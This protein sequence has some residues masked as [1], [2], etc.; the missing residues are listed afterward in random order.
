[1]KEQAVSSQMENHFLLV[2]TLLWEKKASVQGKTMA[3]N[4]S[5]IIWDSMEKHQRRSI[6]QWDFVEEEN[7]TTQQSHAKY[8][9]NCWPKIS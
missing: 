4:N 5:T 9:I 7:Q 2:T 6:L 8:P 3:E 1:M